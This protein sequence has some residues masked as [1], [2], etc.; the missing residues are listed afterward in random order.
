MVHI[1]S[2]LNIYY[3]IS[4]VPPPSSIFFF[5]LRL[6]VFNCTPFL[7]SLKTMSKLKLALVVAV[8]FISSVLANGV[9]GEDIDVG[10]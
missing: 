8:I 9:N 2:N 7:F 5:L 4:I 10:T 6:I 3:Y 1:I